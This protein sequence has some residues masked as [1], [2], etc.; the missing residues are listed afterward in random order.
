MVGRCKGSQFVSIGSHRF[1]EPE[2]TGKLVG[3]EWIIT[4]DPF[5]LMRLQAMFPLATRRADDK[6]VCITATPEHSRDLL[7]FK[8]RHP[9]LFDQERKLRSLAAEYVLKQSRAKEIL[10]EGYQPKLVSF[11]KGEAPRWYQQIAADLFRSV[12]SLLLADELGLGK[13]VSA[14]TALADPGLRP[15]AVIVPVHL[16]IQWRN[17]LKRFLPS[18]AVHTI[19]HTT[20]Y[21]LENVFATC[22]G[23]GAHLDLTKERWKCS[24]CRTPIDKKLST[25][26]PDVTIISYSK[27][28]NWA[29]V[30]A[31]N[32]VTM[33]CDE[34]HE[35]RTGAK[36]DRWKAVH[37]LAKA[38]RYRLAMSATP[39]YNL[40]GE[41]FNVIECVSPGFL[42]PK[43]LF[44]EQWCGYASSS[45]EPELL[46]PEA[47]RSF[48]VQSK[49]ML[50]RSAKE[51]G[52]PVHDCEIIHQTVE[53]DASTFSN[54]TT[55]AEELARAI[56]NDHNRNRGQDTMELDRLIRQATGLA[57]VP[58]VVAFVEMLCEQGEQVVVFAW[59]RAVH[60][61]LAERLA[62]WKPVFYTGTENSTQKA[63][64]VEKF[65]RG[66]AR[67]IVVSLRSGQGLDG[68]QF[69]SCTAVVAELDWTW[70][71]FK[72]N[73]GR[74]ARDGQTRPCKAYC[75]VSDF[76]SDPIVS[77]ALG[78]KKDQLNGLLGER[79]IAPTK[80]FDSAAAIRQL[81]VDYLRKKQLA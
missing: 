25:R 5:V 15:A 79:Q 11:A 28:T 37:T 75:L 47:L 73:V 23:C 66:E 64:A 10:S 32:C 81:A 2:T 71:V 70:A 53:A 13:T 48:L 43:D 27:M 35:L 18:L 6:A 57:K 51:V 17:Q 54:A 21:P 58:A 76:G 19:P 59:H 69:A 7:W 52:I 80:A 20:P 68:L 16:Q 44:Q 72:Q 14:I 46:D 38:V 40:G 30:L 36:T 22:S 9:I 4:G 77:Q 78:L 49:L 26:P 1:R 56:L 12:S 34:A 33:I 55:G 24:I 74:I 45:K 63:A 8:Q 29:R 62:K 41:T 60:D 61:L 42:G 67:V 39:I 31:R 3:K 50:R 65:Q